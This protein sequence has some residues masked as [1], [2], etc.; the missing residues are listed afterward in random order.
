MRL[1]YRSGSLTFREHSGMDRAM[2]PVQTT[3]DIGRVQTVRKAVLLAAVLLL[4]GTFVFVAARWQEDT[5][6]HE[7]IEWIGIVL[8]VV[9][10]VGRTW[11]V[12]Y[13]GGRKSTEVVA[14]GPYSITR[15]PLYVFS[16]IGAAGV[17]AQL[18]SILISVTSAMIVWAI[19]A[20]VVEREERHLTAELGRPYQDYVQRVPR[21]LP[22]LA[23][24]HN[25]DR[26]EI[27][28]AIVVRTFVDACIFLLSIPLAEGFE[29]LQSSGLVP[30]LLR[31]P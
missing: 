25:V 7:T 27:R 2:R 4:L 21:F 5:W 22:N 29:S 10:I 26:L 13:I 30:V 20:S 19:F 31:L 12:L 18:G 1:C 23:L 6:Q 8:M 17:G 14:L 15:N 9:C 3:L 28:P 24:W 11:S 16:I